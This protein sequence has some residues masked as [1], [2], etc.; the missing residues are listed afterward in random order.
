VTHVDVDA[1]EELPGA[2]QAARRARPGGRAVRWMS[3][4]LADP[5]NVLGLVLLLALATRVIWIWL[6]EGSLIF[7]EAYY[8]NASRAI[9]GLDVPTATHYADAVAGL[10][11]NIE[12][13]PL[14]KVVIALS[15]AV[16]GDNALGWRLPSVIAGMVA[17][18]ALWAI[19]RWSGGSSGLAVLAVGL[20]A[21]DNLALIHGRIATLDILFLAPLLVGA[22]LTIRERWLLA[23][24]VFAVAALVK[25]AALFG[26]FAILLY[27]GVRQ[28][29]A[30]RRDGPPRRA[31]VRPFV[32]L[33][34]AFAL[35]F[36]AG[37]WLLDLRFTTFT[38][39]VAHLS[40]ML[41]YGAKLQS[42]GGGAGIASLPW[43]WLV[44]E[45]PI[46]Y[47]RVAV[48]TSVDGTVVSSRATI[49]FR[50][51]MN[52]ILI[53][54]LPLAFGFALW[55]AAR[56]RDPLATWSVTW[57]L[58]NYLPYLA[59]ALVANRITYIYY[60]LPVVPALAV[61]VAL[62]LARS[63]LPRLATGIYLVAVVAAFVAYFPFRQ[64]P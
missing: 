15:M 22:A 44:N 24:V 42:Q 1:P 57:A 56:V 19:V 63:G 36:V 16:L 21:A 6:P 2:G 47:L 59:L 51:V 18:L 12:H 64:L 45:V 39:P 38:D 32:M 13:P 37:L 43:Q 31:V 33:L 35:V 8:V 11:P 60:F 54:V 10:D 9:L 40:H 58:G 27:L 7:D 62:L 41:T 4:T 50:G 52:P 25:L 28:F 48:D 14:G 46:P 5:A 30:W 55:L 34:G 49:D 61:A 3:S 29:Q 26:L 20:F 17:L 53:G 23:G